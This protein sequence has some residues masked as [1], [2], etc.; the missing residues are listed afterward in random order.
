MKYEIVGSYRFDLNKSMPWIES[1]IIDMTILEYSN[2]SIFCASKV[3]IVHAMT[4]SL[5][6]AQVEI[7]AR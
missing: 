7:Q 6:P 2:R 3:N 5:S 4:H 1:V